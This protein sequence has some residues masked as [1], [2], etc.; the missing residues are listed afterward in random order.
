V[1]N[2]LLIEIY[3]REEPLLQAGNWDNLRVAVADLLTATDHPPDDV[4]RA[5]T[6]LRLNGEVLILPDWRDGEPALRQ[7]RL[8]E[9]ESMWEPVLPT[10]T[11]PVW[12]RRQ[13]FLPDDLKRW[14]VR[15][16]VA[17]TIRLL[18]FNRERFGLE[19]T[20][21]HV[22]YLFQERSRPEPDL[23]V[24]DALV[25]LQRLIDQG[26]LA[27]ADRPDDL[28]LALDVVADAFPY[29]HLT[30][31]QARSWE[32]VLH[33][34]FGVPPTHPG[35]ML[36]AGVSSGKTFAFLLPLLT[37]LVYRRLGGEGRRIRALAVYPR[38]SLVVDQFH[39][40][41]DY[42]ARVNERLAAR[43]RPT[44]TDRPALDAAQLLGVSLDLPEERRA[45][46]YALAAVDDAGIEVVLT[47][48]ESLKN[49]ML[50][51][52]AVETYLRHVELIILDEIH[53]FEGLSGCHGTYFLRRLRQLIRRLRNEAD[54]QPAMVGASATVAEPIEHATRVFSS[55]PDGCVGSRRCRKR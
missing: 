4:L 18:S 12:Q 9:S 29:P 48:Q 27:R 49:R 21:A 33:S 36:T 50:D 39:V 14:F 2:W 34:L 7:G 54:F 26:A 38:T 46:R 35:V 53:L 37:L 8:V 24:R 28:R 10:P 16:R 51:A 52:R 13:V 45:L 11:P 47:T 32:A 22:G 3:R 15:S 30:G 44:L 43:G 23:P 6:A 1:A 20:T 19:P 5:L 42:L 17:E 41:R 40:L 55:P 31:F 25:P